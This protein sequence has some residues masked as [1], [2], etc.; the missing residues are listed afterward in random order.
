MYVANKNT[1]LT[2]TSTHKPYANATTGKQPVE[3]LVQERTATSDPTNLLPD[4]S[5]VDELTETKRFL[6]WSSLGISVGVVLLL[7]ALIHYKIIKL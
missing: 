6:L 2:Q 7:L 1:A 4:N 3:Q 5:E